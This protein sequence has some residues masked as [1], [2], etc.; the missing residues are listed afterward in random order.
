MLKIIKF[1][2]NL[3][4]DYRTDYQ[5]ESNQEATF[6]VTAKGLRPLTMT[7]EQFYNE[8]TARMKQYMDN[9]IAK[10]TEEEIYNKHFYKTEKGIII[11]GYEQMN[12]ANQLLYQDLYNKIVKGYLPVISELEEITIREGKVIDLLSGVTATDK[13][14]GD[15]TNEIV[16]IIRCIEVTYWTT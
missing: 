16:V 11:H 7:D 14:D 15:L 1:I 13:E 4:G 8:Y 9:F 2:S 6:I 3:N 10:A 12:E 5:I